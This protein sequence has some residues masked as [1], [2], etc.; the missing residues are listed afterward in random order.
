MTKKRLSFVQRVKLRLFGYVS[1]GYRVKPEW[2]APIEHY[3]FYCKKHGLVVDYPHGFEERLECP[4]CR[5]ELTFK[6]EK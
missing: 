5:K 3:A 1:V 6:E 2:S 4:K